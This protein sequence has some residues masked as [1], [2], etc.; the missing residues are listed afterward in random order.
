[1]RFIWLLIIE[2]ERREDGNP[3]PGWLYL[4]AVGLAAVGLVALALWKA[5]GV[6]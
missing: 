6:L 5:T 2:R 1:M 3:L 4:V